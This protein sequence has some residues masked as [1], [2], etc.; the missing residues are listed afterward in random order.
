MTALFPFV[1]NFRGRVYSCDVVLIKF[2]KARFVD[3]AVIC[4]HSLVSWSGMT[5]RSFRYMSRVR[6]SRYASSDDAEYQSV[7]SF[8][9]TAACCSHPSH[10]KEVPYAHLAALQFSQ[11]KEQCFLTETLRICCIA[12]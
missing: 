4:N 3:L 8:F 11:E 9:V 5:K 1:L 6:D 10:A 2:G 7:M 12:R